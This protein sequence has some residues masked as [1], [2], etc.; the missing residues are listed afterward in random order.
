MKKMKN[1]NLTG[2]ITLLIVPCSTEA[3]TLYQDAVL[4]DNPLLYW[5]FDEAGDS[6]PASSLVNG[7][8]FNTLTAQGNASRVAST[9]TTGGVNLGRAASFDGSN[10]SM[11]SAADLFGDPTPGFNTSPGQ[12][13]I[14]TQLWAVEFWFRGGA[15]NQYFSEAADGA[16]GTNN[17]GLIYNYSGNGIVELFGGGGRTG[18]SGANGTNGEWHHL[19]AAFYGNSGGFSDNLRELYIDGLLTQSTTDAF[20]SGHGLAGIAIG[21]S[22][23]GVDPMTGEIDEYAIYEIG[24]LPNL[25]AR[26]DHVANIAMHYSLAVPEP[27]V[28]LLTGLSMCALL[29]CR[30]RR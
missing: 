29:F 8:S 9:V 13:F 7:S 22:L 27:S 20:S 23:G 4:A 18:T 15:A 6:D 19:V 26:R 25:A 1:A 30:R 2:I 5:S 3:T 16:G 24:N 12:D 11:F 14:A 21:N 10:G 28:G 17:P